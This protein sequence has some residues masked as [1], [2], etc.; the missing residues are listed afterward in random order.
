MNDRQ[1][2]SEVFILPIYQNQ[3]IGSEIV[4]ISIARAR[5]NGQALRLQT[6][7]PI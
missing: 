2:Q 5:H 3:G 6:L 4:T 7:K 1:I